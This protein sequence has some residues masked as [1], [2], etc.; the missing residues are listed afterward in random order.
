MGFNM[1]LLHFVEIGS[2][3]VALQFML[4]QKNMLSTAR[5]ISIIFNLGF[6]IICW[7][8][9][10]LHHA[11]IAAVMSGTYKSFVFR[12]KIKRIFVCWLQISKYQILSFKMLVNAIRNA[13]LII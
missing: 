6:S 5:M 4:L 9:N 1:W 13:L 3:I 11:F 10:A 7:L 2:W 12:K 8:R